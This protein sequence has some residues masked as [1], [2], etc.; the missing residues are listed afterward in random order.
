MRREQV[1]AR[2]SY[3]C[4]Y[5]GE[6]FEPDALTVDHVQPRMRGIA[7]MTLAG[8]SARG[9]NHHVPDTSILYSRRLPHGPVVR[10]R[11]TSDEGVQPVIAV[12]EVDRRAGTP[13]EFE[14]GFPPPLV[15]SE[16]T[17]EAEV[18]MA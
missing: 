11:R 4:V 2:D 5:C 9:D 14:G 17:T 18:P 8:R 15:I 16:G 3:H 6:A 7:A 12:L 1:F 13:R 10:I